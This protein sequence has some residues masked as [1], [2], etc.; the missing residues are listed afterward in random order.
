M[1]STV[2]LALSTHRPDVAVQLVSVVAFDGRL[3]VVPTVEFEET[4][5]ILR[6]WNEGVR[7]RAEK[8]GRKG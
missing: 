1:D 8:K 7:E 2:D 5:R 6:E 3:V 4:C